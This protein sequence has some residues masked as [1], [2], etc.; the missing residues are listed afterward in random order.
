[1]ITKISLINKIDDEEEEEEGLFKIAK[2]KPITTPTQFGIG[3]SAV[4]GATLPKPVEV[5]SS[6]YGI[7]DLNKPEQ[8]G[9][10]QKGVIGAFG[11]WEAKK[12]AN[13]EL[14][15]MEDFG[16]EV[17]SE[18]VALA[19]SRYGEDYSKK[20]SSIEEVAVIYE[21]IT[22][23]PKEEALKDIEGI[24]DRN[25]FFTA[26]PEKYKEA[27]KLKQ[28]L[29]DIRTRVAE[30]GKDLIGQFGWTGMVVMMGYQAVDAIYKGGM[31]V[32]DRVIKGEKLQQAVKR[33]QEAYIK[34]TGK[35]KSSLSN[36]D[37]RIAQSLNQTLKQY[38]KEIFPL[39]SVQ[40][41][42]EVFMGQAGNIT[43]IVKI[44]QG[45][46][47]VTPE[48]ITQSQAL[49]KMEALQVTQQLLNINPALAS[50]FLKAV[51]KPPEA[52]TMG[53]EAETPAIPAEIAGLAEEARKIVTDIE[54]KAKTIPQDEF[55]KYYQDKLGV[56]WKNNKPLYYDVHN[57]LT[58]KIEKGELE[59][60]NNIWESVK[61]IKPTDKQIYKSEN[62]TVKTSWDI[63]Q[64][65]GDDDKRIISNFTE[66]IKKEYPDKKL[67]ISVGGQ[68]ISLAGE[69]GFR[70]TTPTDAEID[71]MFPYYKKTREILK[72]LEKEGIPRKELW[73]GS[74]MFHE[75]AHTLGIK[76]EIEADKFSNKMMKKWA[77]AQATAKPTTEQPS[78][79]APV[80]EK[81]ISEPEIELAS[82]VQ[83]NKAYSIAKS[84]AMVSELGKLKP[85][86]RKIAE[87][88][89]GQKSVEKMTPEEAEMFIDQLNRLP[90]PKYRDGKLVPPSIPRT[91]KL[92][93]QD[94]FKKQYGEPTPIWLLTD[95]T[96][97]ATKLGIKP[98]VEPF[99]K[100]KQEF[101]LEFRKSSNLVD[102]MVNK[103]NQIAKT[104]GFERIK[105][106]IKNIPTKAENKMA[107]LI[108]KHET[109][110]SGL[111]PKEEDIFKYFRNLSKDIWR[112]ENEVREK[113]DLPPIKYKTAYFRH[114]ADAMAKEM[115][116]GKYPFP[117]GIKYW[118]E[119][120]VGKKI[121]N[122]ME[123]HRKLSDD[124]I[125]LWSKDIRAVTKAMLW[126]GLKEIHLAEPAKYLNEQ[127]NAI[128]KD[129]PEYK[130]LTPR[131]QAA[132][133][134]TR[135][136]PAS[137]K[138]WLIDY[139]NQVLKGQ[140]T[141]LDASLNRIVTK[142][143]LKGIFDKVLSPFGRAVGRTPITNLF[144]LS[145]RMI[146]SGTMGWV[147]RQMI[148]NAF[149]QTQN[150]ALY[151]VKATIKAMLP[152]GIDKNLKDLLSESLFMKSYTGFEELP[153]D[154]MGKLEKAWLKPYGIVAV[155]NA[156]QGMKAAYW[157][158]LELIK[159]PKFKK[160]GW[161][162]PQR[163]K[164]TP[165]GFLYPSEKEKL[166][167][168]MEFGASCTQYQYIPMGMPGVFRYKV[169]IP[170]TRLQSWWMNYFTKFLNEAKD[171]GLKGKPSWSG[172]GGP[173]LPW[174]RRVNFAKYL[175][176]GGAILTAMGYK[177]SFM[178]G[179]L[180]GYLSPA[181][182]LGI[183]FY[184]YAIADSD[185]QKKRA[186]NQMYYAWK[187]F[188]PGSLA[189]RDFISVWNGEKELEEILFYG[190]EEE[191]KKVE[192]TVIGKPSISKITIPKISKIKI[193]K[194]SPIKIKF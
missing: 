34:E 179:V 86:Y 133:D 78:P 111:S 40:V 24:K 88:F 47:K 98:L 93:I 145:G 150:L 45:A 75:L 77:K 126:N 31:V 108:N 37:F 153:V 4:G 69:E 147:P 107:E 42:Q 30:P 22:G 104:P 162:D 189:W 3:A 161:A 174:S 50:E 144:S 113:L 159:D 102:R 109:T 136:M 7:H 194:I 44:I 25:V 157:N 41:P 67:T 140:E 138:K 115:L 103:L 82:P 156:K 100:G 192:P 33:I 54:N 46:G 39:Q 134:Q 180:P 55:T 21:R 101:D 91:T 121:F 143:G 6:Q 168:E 125:D 151:G 85:Q 20:G 146:I 99:E 48:A 92:T 185:W 123:F 124:L 83:V 74:D 89:T 80:A 64:K 27:V 182:Q 114:T 11:T 163:T 59:S 187:A 139:V 56:L 193:N 90:E 116:E 132:Y 141:E 8:M 43:N 70:M 160:Y 176:I 165:K 10:I 49:S 112:R 142:S 58:S 1:M 79:V 110:P 29:S 16:S 63:M 53:K 184:N 76:N 171:R 97:Y 118:S 18:A 84:K 62:I 26:P 60:A 19:K 87:I 81:A 154:L 51:E 68:L 170:F 152:A 57:Y 5:P 181:G 127:L 186:L 178:I 169:G 191:K 175:I 155:N 131:E 122:P 128:S 17:T 94:F 188:I 52:V 71:I 164:D 173:T 137:T 66:F 119:K 65:L 38:G 13:P 167:K 177:R 12:K 106:K 36:N 117:Q 96:Y 15:K 35:F 183:G 95:Q 120:I 61:G 190:K 73:T 105:S 149:Q 23:T 129:L 135:V 72:Q 148:R 166:L 28:Y 130:N 14:Q 172:E 9:K 32:E 2:I 158:I